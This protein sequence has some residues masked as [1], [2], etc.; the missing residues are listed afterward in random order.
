[1]IISGIAD[2]DYQFVSVENC[3]M[4]KPNDPPYRNINGPVLPNWKYP[5]MKGMSDFVHGRELRAGLQTSPG[6]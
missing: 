6:P 5:D 4:K 2:F 1:M 3:W